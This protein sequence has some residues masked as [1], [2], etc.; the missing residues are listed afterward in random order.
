MDYK[1]ATPFYLKS[2]KKNIKDKS[3]VYMRITL[4]G[5]RTEIC[6]NQSIQA[7]NSNKRLERAKG[8]REEICIFNT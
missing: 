2:S 3:P 1:L 5:V 4:N 6:P 7:E 8:N